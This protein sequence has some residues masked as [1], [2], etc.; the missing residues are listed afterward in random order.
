MRGFV[1]VPKPWH[2]HSNPTS[3]VFIITA[4]KD[5]W[6]LQLEWNPCVVKSEGKIMT[7]CLGVNFETKAIVLFTNT[8][9]LEIQT[10]E[11]WAQ[12]ISSNTGIHLKN[13][14]SP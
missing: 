13:Q 12:L 1:T 4:L 10:E 2:L 5:V 14:G 6:V 3:T 8:W 9:I 7:D 11:K